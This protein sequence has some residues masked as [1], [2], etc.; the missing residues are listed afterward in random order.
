MRAV[1]FFVYI[2]ENRLIGEKCLTETILSSYDIRI[3]DREKYSVFFERE[4]RED[5]DMG[6]L[7]YS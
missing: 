6:I 2:P 4:K 1:G 5:S 7:L 3:R